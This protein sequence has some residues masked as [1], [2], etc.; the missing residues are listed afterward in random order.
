MSWG[1][2]H[3]EAVVPFLLVIGLTGGCSAAKPPHG[4][5][6]PARANLVLPAD[7]SV[8]LATEFGRS[9]WPATC[10]GIESTQHTVFL[11]YYRDHQ[12]HESLERNNPQR[13]FRSYRI[14]FQQR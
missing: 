9:D 8:S 1:K 10:G 11:E 6:G 5:R 3:L 4:I 7:G 13:T 14:G 12:G 2:R